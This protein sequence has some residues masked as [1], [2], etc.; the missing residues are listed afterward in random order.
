MRKAMLVVALLATLPLVLAGPNLAKGTTHEVSTKLVA[1]NL[2]KRT[3]T[4]E[5]S[6]GDDMTMPVRGEA[7][8][9]LKSQIV[10]VGDSVIATCQDD[11]QGNHEAVI[12]LRPAVA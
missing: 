2:E 6:D 11:D 9:S 5:G 10:K 1:V 8:A 12:G 4:L 7:L 3:V